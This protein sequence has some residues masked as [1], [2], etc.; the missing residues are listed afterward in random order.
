MDGVDETGSR[1]NYRQ[2]HSHVDLIHQP[3]SLVIGGG[4]GGPSKS[5]L[6]LHLIQGH[7]AIH[8][9]KLLTLPAI[10]MESDRRRASWSG[11]VSCQVP[12]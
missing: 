9:L 1:T 2:V 11:P 10:D 3:T 8:Q 7:P 6:I 5:G 4:G 12:R